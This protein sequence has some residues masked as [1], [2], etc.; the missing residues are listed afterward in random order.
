MA[1]LLEVIGK[2]NT[3]NELVTDLFATFHYLST[4]LDNALIESENGS[5]D[6]KI[7][8][9]NKF[10]CIMSLKLIVASNMKQINF[11]KPFYPILHKNALN[12]EGKQCSLLIASRSVL[13]RMP[14]DLL[15]LY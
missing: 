7:N 8:R 3:N 1:T 10:Y 5:I 14:S 12:S 9:G 15:Q 11:M 4:T 13:L 6:A 2:L